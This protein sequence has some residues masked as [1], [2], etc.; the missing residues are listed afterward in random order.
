MTTSEQ[1]QHFTTFALALTKQEGEHLALDEIF[2]RWWE[3]NHRDE[4]LVA[5]QEAVDSFETGER[6]RPAK[7][8]LA[9][10]RTA[11]ARTRS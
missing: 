1:L 7:E 6:G 9:E 8:F 4:D 2:Q 11:R 5:I 3:E 10:Q